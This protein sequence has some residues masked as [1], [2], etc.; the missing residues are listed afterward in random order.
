MQMSRDEDFGFTS[1]APAEDLSVCDRCFG[2]EDIQRFIRNIADSLVCD[3]C[4]RHARVNAVAAPLAE[5]VEF[6]LEAIEREYGRAVDTLGFESAEGGYQ[7]ANWDSDELVSDVIELELPNDGDGRLQEVIVECLG[8][9][10]W[11]ERNPYSLAEDERYITSW[12]NFCKYVKHERRYFFVRRSR[13]EQAYE[14]TLSPAKLL[15]FIGDACE[16]SRLLRT[17]R[18]GALL[19]RARQRRIGELL[20]S[21]LDFGPPPKELAVRSNRMSPA[22]I[23]MFYGSDQV[24]T[25][26]AE[27]DDDPTLGISVGTFSITREA[28]LLD[29]TLLQRSFR[30]FERQADSDE[31]NRDVLSFLNSFVESVAS[32]VE[33]GN[34]EH[35]DYVPTQI[36]TEWFRTTFLHDGSPIDGICYPS[37]QR[38]GGK[39]FVLFADRENIV[40]TPTQVK[41]SAGPGP[42]GEWLVRSRQESAWLRLVR[43]RVIRDV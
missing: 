27:I 34:R 7:G 14:E 23:V 15:R 37:T 9:E 25:A 6:M 2:D 19:Y 24:D 30:F 12:D 13:D 4:G 11:C 28:T 8:D 39:S 35:V 29:L 33:P 5:V 36:V 18:K 40:L 41:K 26:V 16:Q 17:L 22:G 38:P 1:T 43:R 32:K 20:T 42:L 31:L 21:G 3:F 10:P